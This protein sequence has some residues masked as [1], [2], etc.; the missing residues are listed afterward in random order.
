MDIATT[1][2]SLRRLAAVLSSEVGRPQSPAMAVRVL[3]NLSMS[4]ETFPWF[5]E[6]EKEVVLVAASERNVS[7]ILVNVIADVYG[8]HCL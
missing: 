1:E 4:V 8:M 6:I 7:D 5:L 3:A 2:G